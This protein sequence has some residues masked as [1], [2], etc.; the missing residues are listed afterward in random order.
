MSPIAKNSLLSS[1]SSNARTDACPI[2]CFFFFN[3]TATT[4]ISPLPLHGALPISRR[5]N[6]DGQ[7]QQR[8]QPGEPLV[9]LAVFAVDRSEEHTA[10]L[11]SPCNLVC[12]R[13]L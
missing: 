3:D 6:H 1:L 11:Q 5:G 12:R 2:F 8:K 7:R 9:Q 13:L 10:E 4:K